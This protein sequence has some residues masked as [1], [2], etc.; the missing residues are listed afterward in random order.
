MKIFENVVAANGHEARTI[1]MFVTLLVLLAVSM[2]GFSGVARAAQTGAGNGRCLLVLERN[3]RVN[4]ARHAP[5]STFDLTEI[6]SSRKKGGKLM[7]R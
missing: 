5:G 1:Q 4:V 2:F 7:V 6:V 3:P